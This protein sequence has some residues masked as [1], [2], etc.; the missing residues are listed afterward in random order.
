M[1]ISTNNA[2]RQLSIYKESIPYQ[3]GT[4]S[5]VY[6]QTIGIYA[7]LTLVETLNITLFAVTI[8]PELAPISI[9]TIEP[10]NP[11]TPSE[12]IDKI[13]EVLSTH[14]PDGDFVG[15][16]LNNNQIKISPKNPAYNNLH[17]DIFTEGTPNEIISDYFT[18]YT[19]EKY[20]IELIDPSVFLFA[21]P[22]TNILIEDGDFYAFDCT[23]QKINS[24]GAPVKKIIITALADNVI[25]A[26]PPIIGDLIISNINQKSI[27]HN[28]NSR[29]ITAL[30]YSDS[31]SSFGVIN[32]RLSVEQQIYSSGVTSENEITLPDDFIFFQAEIIIFKFL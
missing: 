28:L 24:P 25:G 13:I 16:K 15:V 6:H 22:W 32:R 17:L 23:V 18:T 11:L 10:D 20:V 4:I 29:L 26:I 12:W 9:F 27:T 1:G 5:S 2:S 3:N 7:I 30:I 31:F 8:T 19:E 21:L 14:Y